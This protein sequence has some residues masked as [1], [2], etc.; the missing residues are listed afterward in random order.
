MFRFNKVLRRTTG[1]VSALA[2]LA[3]SA[4][5]AQETDGTAG[6]GAEKTVEA[7]AA[8]SPEC[9]WMGQRVLSLL[10][11]DD[12]NTA[13]DFIEAYDRFG[14]PAEHIGVAFRCLVKVGPSAED[15]EPGLPERSRACW[16]NPALDP[17]SLRPPVEGADDH[18]QDQQQEQQDQQ[19]EQQEGEQPAQNGEENQNNAPE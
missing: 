5:L 15:S 19:Q 16:G 6:N 11:R 10:W 12:I 14:C 8:G 2:L 17:A 1:L 9:A 7:P 18:Q 13:N 4:A 3:G